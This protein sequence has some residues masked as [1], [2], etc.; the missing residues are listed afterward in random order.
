MRGIIH[1]H[2]NYSHDGRNSPEELAEF[3][4]K[5]KLGF[6]ALTDHAED[7]TEGRYRELVEHCRA[8]SVDGVRLI[9]G[10]EFRFRGMPGL[11]LLACGLEQW[12]EPRSADEFMSVTRPRAQLTVVAHPVLTRH[13]IPPSVLAGIDA[14]EVWNG[15]YNTRYLPDPRSVRILHR[16]RGARP[17]VVGTVGPDMH[18]CS[19]FRETRMAVADSSLEPLDEI[20]EGR[21]RNECKTMSFGPD[22]AWGP[23]RLGALTI[24]RDALDWVNWTHDRWKMRNRDR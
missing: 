2:S 14:I 19:N 24:A 1:V 17:E 20:R 21:F 11:H 9:P 22:V 13:R 16:V 8:V 10:L 12:S 18:D 4:R 6:I 15:T 5:N 7:L 3:A 23:V